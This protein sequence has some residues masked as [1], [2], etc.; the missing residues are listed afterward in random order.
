VAKRQRPPTWLEVAI[1]GAGLRTAIKATTWAYEW[2]VTREALGHEPSVEEV[3]DWWKQSHRTA[4]RDQ[5]EF[6][7]AFP[8]LDTPAKIYESEEAR[9]SVAGLARLGEK[10]DK[11]GEERR[12]RREL[13]AIKAVMLRAD[14]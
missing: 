2:A 3:A 12:A 8:M 13:D 9:E 6:R 4:Y 7:K 14:Q 11:W 10:I 1:A 5:A